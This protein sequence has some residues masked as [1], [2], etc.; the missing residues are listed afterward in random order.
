MQTNVDNG[1]V[2]TEGGQSPQKTKQLLEGAGFAMSGVSLII[3]GVLA[4]E[5]LGGIVVAGG[6]LLALHGAGR[7]Q[8]QYATLIDEPQDSFQDNPAEWIMISGFVI[9]M[10]AMLVVS[11]W[12]IIA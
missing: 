1:L 10:A 6:G 9:A 8:G 5:S 7:M 11:L 12:Q 3:T 4:M 2:E